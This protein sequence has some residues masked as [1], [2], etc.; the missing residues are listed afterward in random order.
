LTRRFFTDVALSGELSWEV[1]GDTNANGLITALE[2]QNIS[3]MYFSGSSPTLGGLV[4]PDSEKEKLMFLF[5]EGN[6]ILTLSHQNQSASANARL[7][8]PYAADVKVYPHEACILF[9]DSI[10]NYWRFLGKS[11]T[12]IP[13]IISTGEAKIN[14]IKITTSL[15]PV[16]NNSEINNLNIADQS[17]LRI[18]TGT[19]IS[20]FIASND[21]NGKLLFLHN[22]TGD[23]IQ[24]KNNSSSST[25][26]NRILTGKG[27]DIY[28]PND[29]VTIFQYDNTSQFWRIAG[30]SGG[31]GSTLRDRYISSNSSVIKFERII[32]DTSQNSIDLTLP[33][34]PVDGDLIGIIDASGTFGTNNVNLLGNGKKINNELQD[35]SLD[36]N[37]MYIEL[38]YWN[39]SWRFLDVPLLK[40][41]LSGLTALIQSGDFSPRSV[42]SPS[43]VNQDIGTVYFQTDGSIWRKIGPNND[44][45]T[46]FG[47]K[48][49]LETL[50]YSSWSVPNQDLEIFIP[51]NFNNIPIINVYDNSTLEFI[52]TEVKHYSRDL[53]SILINWEIRDVIF[54]SGP[55]SPSLQILI[56]CK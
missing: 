26:G 30:G 1:R 7:Y 41:E 25:L 20:G 8:L 44:D 2:T 28:L 23:E 29:S 55:S 3:T 24:I 9:Y 11:T 43:G 13:D 46:K 54:P 12:Y 17:F 36:I 35:Y 6:G 22:V 56:V 49:T 37:G 32:A 4:N 47:E 5:Y 51:H 16:I 53:S 21:D 52:Q 19:S 15:Q 27:Y 45:W 14:E 40:E 50:T 10:N 39:G 34:S 48:E 18:T 38:H 33:S 31:S 42:P